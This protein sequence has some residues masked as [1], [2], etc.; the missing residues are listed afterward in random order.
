MKRRKKR[1]DR[2]HIVYVLRVKNSE[3]VGVTYVQDNSPAKSLRRRWK[4]HVQR[5]LTELRDWTLC[6]AIRKYGM[7]AFETE[8][9]EIVRGKDAAHKLERAYIRELNPKLNSDKR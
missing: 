2:N 7:E 5:A 8:I 6:K 3:Y 1:C 4:K 9:L